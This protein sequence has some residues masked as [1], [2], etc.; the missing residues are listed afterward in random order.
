MLRSGVTRLAGG[1]IPFVSSATAETLALQQADFRREVI[2]YGLEAL[3]S[4]ELNTIS[5]VAR[6]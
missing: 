1:L 2:N 4:D 3:V 5:G 6:V